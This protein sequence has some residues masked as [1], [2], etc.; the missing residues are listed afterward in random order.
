MASP[1]PPTT[2][3]DSAPF[4]LSPLGLPALL[5]PQLWNGK[6]NVALLSLSSHSAIYH[7]VKHERTKK[8]VGRG[9]FQHILKQCL[10][11]EL[12]RP[13]R[14]PSAEDVTWGVAPLPPSPSAPFPPSSR[15]RLVGAPRLACRCGRD[16]Q[17]VAARA[18]G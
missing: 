12:D 10:S 3:C 8:K 16:D 4:H 18:A 9:S 11:R 17:V 13:P 15:S 7:S 1:P 14:L 6:R 2:P 5:T